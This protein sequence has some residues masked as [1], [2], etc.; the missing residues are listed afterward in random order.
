M[1]LNKNLLDVSPPLLPKGIATVILD[2]KQVGFA[3]QGAGKAPVPR[4][5]RNISARLPK[6]YV[7]MVLV[8]PRLV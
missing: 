7:Q 2:E 6:I 1:K 3:R 4:I 5:L 8:R